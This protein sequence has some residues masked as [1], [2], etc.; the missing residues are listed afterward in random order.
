MQNMETKVSRSIKRKYD[1]EFWRKV[2][3]A[4]TRS[5]AVS[6]LRERYAA[7]TT[8]G[9]MKNWDLAQALSGPKP[10]VNHVCP[11]N[12]VLYGASA[13]GKTCREFAKDNGL[14]VKVI[15]GAR[16]H[17]KDYNSEDVLLLETFDAAPKMNPLELAN[18]LD[19]HEAT[20]LGYHV[21]ETPPKYVFIVSQGHPNSW[22]K[23]ANDRDWNRVLQR[24]SKISKETDQTAQ[25]KTR[26][27]FENEKSAPVSGF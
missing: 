1:D 10:Y 3:D 14:S 17:R 23:P 11:H 12:W 13:T 2:S 26:P 25:A 19:G 21:R 16:G 20:I 27:D 4:S 6:I 7:S 8:K 24:I 18:L 5:D 15:R 9:F 22:I